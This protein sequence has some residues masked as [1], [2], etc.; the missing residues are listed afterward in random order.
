MK[1]SLPEVSGPSSR[2]SPGQTVNFTCT[3]TG[4]FPKNI[5][6][7]WFENGMELPVLQTFIFLP[8]DTLS[9]TIVSTT[10]VTLDLSSFHSQ[11]TCQVAHSTLPRPL[12]RHV[13]ISKF[14]QGKGPTHPP[15]WPAVG[16]YVIFPVWPNSL[17][18]SY[19]FFSKSLVGRVQGSLSHTI[20]LLT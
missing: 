18:S 17:A 14:L 12:N 13:N 11:I 3:S 1:P 7:K 9:Y 5:Y 15:K 6:L 16:D 19:L 10:Q 2:V 20:I 4:F 8:K